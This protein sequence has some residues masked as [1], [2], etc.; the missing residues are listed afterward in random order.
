MGQ[1]TQD[2]E[3]MRQAIRGNV[4]IIKDLLKQAEAYRSIIDTIEDEPT[5]QRFEKNVED[6][7]K[8]ID[9][10]VK[11]TDY[12]FDQYIKLASANGQIITSV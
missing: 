5:K 8:T 4:A 1:T 3:D 9:S 2:Y 12:I 11:Q 10:L 6:I 7:F